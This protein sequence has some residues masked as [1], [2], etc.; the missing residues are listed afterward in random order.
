[1]AGKHH[2][3]RRNDGR[4]HDLADGHLDEEEMHMMED[5][6]E[7]LAG[8]LDEMPVGAPMSEELLEI[9]HI[10]FTPQEAELG[11]KLPF[12]NT[13]LDELS[14]MTGVPLTELEPILDGMVSKGT[15]FR[16]SKGGVTKY[17]LLPTIVGFSETPFWPGKDNERVRALAPLWNSYFKSA[18]GRE[19]GDRKVP[20]LR[21]VPVEEELAAETQVLPFETVSKLVEEADYRVV[22]Y[23]PCRQFRAYVGEG[24]DHE[25]EN[26]FHFG[27]MGRYMVEQGMGRELTLEE[28]VEKLR[29]AH[30]E[31]LVFSTD[32]YQGKV[33]TICSCCGCCCGFI[34]ARKEMGY[35][36]ALAPS[37]YTARVDGENCTGCGDCEERCPVGAISLDDD[38]VAVVEE[39]QCLGCGVCIPTCS[40]E[41]LTLERRENAGEI[42]PLP[43][44]IA[45]QMQKRP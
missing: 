25:R 29:E 36:N 9:L 41:A 33:S 15:V 17:R 13:G 32:N 27:S 1:M 40:G 26:C 10:L 5:V 4:P 42:L 43:E 39:A 35:A 16:S 45:A 28:T 7:A 44:F 6:Y 31:G 21:V 2:T 30:E 11:T 12:M 8:H 18:F 24:C 20:L 38:M 23:C 34:Q 22:A 19:I 3:A 37:N 14:G